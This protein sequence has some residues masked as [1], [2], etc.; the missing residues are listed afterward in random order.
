MPAINQKIADWQ[1]WLDTVSHLAARNGA[2]QLSLSQKAGGAAAS[3]LV[4][5]V[6]LLDVEDE[7]AL[8]IERPAAGDIAAQMTPDQVVSVLAVND[9]QRWRGRCKVERSV[10]F[11]LN[12][13][14]TVPAIKLS[15]ALAVESGQRRDSF[16]VDTSAVDLP[17]VRLTYA[18]GELNDKPEVTAGES[19]TIVGRMLNLSGGGMGLSVEH[20]KPIA[21][22]P[23]SGGRYRCEFSLPTFATPIVLH[24]RLVHVEP[25][26]G[27]TYLG[28]EFEFT[29][30]EDHRHLRTHIVKFATQLERLHL[31]R[32]RGA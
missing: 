16:R 2:V 30:P 3:D 18:P 20:V 28:L 32:Q 23:V 8:I 12:D 19:G 29:G 6:R 10:K 27:G 5:R 9:R 4:C 1:C 14:T 13:A 25:V 21:H 24:A 11:T 26:A 15:A 22:K 17:L 7:G 31:R